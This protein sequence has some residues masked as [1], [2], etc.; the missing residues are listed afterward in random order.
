MGRGLIAGAIGTALMTGWQTLA[1]KLQASGEKSGPPSDKP[2]ADP[3]E[4]ASAPAKVAKRV[5]E[6]VFHKQVSPD[7][8]PAL[9]N[10]MHWGYGAGWG[11]MCGIVASSAGKSRLRDG[12]LFGTF[13]WIMSYIQ[14]VP[15]GLYEPPW[16]TRRKTS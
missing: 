13:V 6:G 9:T 11:T 12:M 15:M 2:P 4:A 1:A 7:L 8:I 3:W 5:G 14:L 16:N 10:A